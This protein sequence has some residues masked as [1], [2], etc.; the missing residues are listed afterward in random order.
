MLTNVGEYVFNYCV[1]LT[2]VTFKAVVPPTMTGD[3]ALNYSS[4]P[5]YVPA[6]SVNAYQTAPGWSSYASRIQAIA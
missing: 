3:I 6:A 5:I 4:C 2:S 1:G